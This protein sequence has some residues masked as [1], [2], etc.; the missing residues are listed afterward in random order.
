MSLNIRNK[1]AS[2]EYH[3]DQ[4][5]TAG[6]VLTGT[7][8]KSVRDSRASISEAYCY[9]HNGDVWVKNMHINIYEPGGRSNHDPKRE[10]KLL[11]NKDEIK[12]I[13]KELKVKGTTLIPLKMFINE[14][15]YAK[16]QIALA[17]GK[18]D[19]DKREDIKEKDAKREM[20][21]VKKIRR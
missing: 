16:L 12:K 18:K 20:D 2:F 8:I 1:K 3:I 4:D 11:L 10:R 14:N 13:E 17:K 21:R 7:E 19:Y 6:I 9:I 15:G 5:F